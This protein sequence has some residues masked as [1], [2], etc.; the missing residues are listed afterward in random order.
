MEDINVINNPSKDNA[1]EAKA[2]KKKR[3]LVIT[4]DSEVF[5]SDKFVS[6]FEMFGGR[7]TE[8]KDL[9]GRLDG[10]CDVSFGIISGNFGFIPANYVV[11]KYDKVPSCKKE[12]EELQERKD[13][14]GQI[15]YITNAKV[16]DK[17]VVCVPKDMFG[18]LLDALPSE[19]VIA[20]TSLGYRSEC[21]KRGWTFYL[22]NGARVGKSN[23]D[24]IVSEIKELK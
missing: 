22:R 10:I 21:K 17:I 20:V 11:M 19:K 18:M 16:F 6:A 7:M 9:V 2:G 14:V 8:V 1:K 5:L 23:A 4:N 13:F 15:K 24:A 12:Y 3:V